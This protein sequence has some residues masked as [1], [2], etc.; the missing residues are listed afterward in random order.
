MNTMQSFRDGPRA[1][2]WSQVSRVLRLIC[3]CLV[4]LT[5][6]VL[7]FWCAVDKQWDEATFFLVLAW[8]AEVDYKRLSING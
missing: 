5:G 1:S 6:F 2:F 7:A 3:A 4:A 8:W